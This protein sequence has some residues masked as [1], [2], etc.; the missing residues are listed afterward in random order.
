MKEFETRLAVVGVG[1]W[2]KNLLREFNDLTPVV[3]TCTS[4]KNEETM[5]WLKD[6]Y[7]LADRKSFDEILQSKEVDGVVIA[8]PIDTH[9]ELVYRALSA[10]KHVFVEKPPTPS[11]LTTLKLYQLAEKQD[12]VFSTDNLLLFHPAFKKIQ[13][14]L[15]NKTPQ[16]LEFQYEKNGTFNEDIYWNLAYHDIYLAMKLMGNPQALRIIKRQAGVTEVDTLEFLMEYHGGREVHSLINRLNEKEKFRRVRIEFNTQT[17]LWEDNDL[18]EVNNGERKAIVIEEGNP[19][20]D[21]CRDYLRR[22]KQEVVID[23][24]QQL[25]M[26]TLKVIE[27]LKKLS[28]SEV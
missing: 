17:L 3:V 18:F 23:P 15:D 28:P 27:E 2:G 13:E 24:N 4:G 7:P 19:L 16:R 26:D 25:V 5:Q 14:I 11:S 6:N 12:L 1:R 22:I 8:T 9:E 21:V 20:E 10:G